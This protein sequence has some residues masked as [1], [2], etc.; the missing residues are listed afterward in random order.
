MPRQLL[1]QI[2]IYLTRKNLRKHGVN[3]VAIVGNGQTSIA[4]E[5]I[6][7]VLKTKHA[8]RRN[9]EIPETELSIPLSI[10]G[11]KVYPQNMYEW[12][13]TVLRV[14]LQILIVKPH[15][16]VLVLEIS[17]VKKD[18]A[19]FWLNIIQ[20]KVVVICGE[21]SL[22][23]KGST[24]CHPEL[25]PAA[26]ERSDSGRGDSGSLPFRPTRFRNKFG[27]TNLK[28]VHIKRDKSLKP[29]FKAAREVGKQFGIS[30]E[31][32]EGLKNFEMPPPRIRV[33]KGKRGQIVIDSSYH[34]SPP[35]LKSVLELSD[36]LEG[37]KILI[38][39]RPKDKN[40]VGPKYQVLELRDRIPTSHLTHH[41]SIVRG[42]KT[43]TRKL[44]EDLTG[45][46][47]P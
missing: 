45:R 32:E 4:R 12:I 10:L 6:Y 33:L 2:L 17:D 9:V 38:T 19:E 40:L 46:L 7:A 15:R 31:A 11:A 36:Q 20:P 27:M 43:K 35:P 47:Q 14:A 41:T 13:Q 24:L 16:H 8:V 28:I 37:E 42:R 39:D 1:R 5:A 23:L 25:P 3:V 22:Y 21:T 26:L 29:Y 18:L 30:K 44:L 34:Y